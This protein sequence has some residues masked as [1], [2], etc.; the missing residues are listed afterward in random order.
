MF[1][2]MRSG[3]HFIF[4]GL[5]G[6]AKKLLRL[7]LPYHW[8]IGLRRWCD[9]LWR[10]QDSECCKSRHVTSTELII[11]TPVWFERA[12]NSETDRN[13]LR[14]L[15]VAPWLMTGGAD[16]MT[17][18]WFRALDGKWCEKYFVS[19]LPNRNNWLSKIIDC[20]SGIYDLPA[21]GHIRRAEMVKF[22]LDIVKRKKIDILHIMNSE[23]AFDALPKLKKCFPELKIVAQFHCFDYRADGKKAGYPHDI[24][25]Y[26]DHFI[27]SYNIE[28]I[29]LKDEILELYPCIEPKKFKVIHGSIDCG[30]FN[31]DRDRPGSEILDKRRSGVLNLLFIGRLDRQK[32]PLRLIDI[33]RELRR[34]K[35]DF[36]MHVIGDGSLESQKREFLARLERENLQKQVLW[37]GEQSLELMIDWYGIADVLLLTSDWEGVPMVLYQ[38][39]A[40]RVVPVVADVGGCA[41]L[42]T[43]ACGYLVAEKENAQAYVSAIKELLDDQRR[44]EMGALARQRMLEHFSLADLDSE[45]RTFYGSL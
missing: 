6:Y 19:T 30:Y 38:A 18:D 17:V 22:L 10:L 44:Q 34:G 2:S 43:P 25:P 12:Y 42:V 27:D 33:A 20:A 35:V 13:K 39:M 15:Y 24:P 32:Q 37:Y 28:Y 4:N 3:L 26:Y 41:E 40:M 21:L 5:I 29:Q 9:R 45:Y 31:P 8:R 16:T 7:L 11:T 23:V 14:I 1:T 36:V